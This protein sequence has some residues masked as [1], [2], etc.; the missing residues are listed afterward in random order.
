MRTL[1]ALLWLILPAE[2]TS[3]LVQTEGGSVSIVKELDARTCK[4]AKCEL[5]KQTTCFPT[6]CDSEGNL[7]Y[8]DP[9]RSSCDMAGSSWRPKLV[10]CLE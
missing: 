3:L 7:Q 9:T 4:I 5:D 8:V 2:A 1:L 10:E 6:K